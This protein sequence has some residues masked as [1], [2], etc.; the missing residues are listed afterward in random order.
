MLVWLLL[1]GGCSSCHQLHPWCRYAGVAC[2]EW[3]R[4]R[5]LTRREFLNVNPGAQ[6]NNDKSHVN[7]TRSGRGTHHRR[8]F[9]VAINLILPLVL[10]YRTAS[11]K[12]ELNAQISFIHMQV[13]PSPFPFPSHFLLISRTS[14]PNELKILLV[15]SSRWYFNMRSKVMI[16]CVGPS[17]PVSYV[18]QYPFVYKSLTNRRQMTASSAGAPA[19]KNP[20]KTYIKR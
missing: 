19:R 3:L 9:I 5:V 4:T 20:T 13:V 14:A 18:V 2:Q 6:R 17:W 7:P 11:S 12:T 10:L 1:T 16:R 8:L 15:F